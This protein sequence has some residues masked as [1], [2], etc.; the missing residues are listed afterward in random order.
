VKKLA[1]VSMGLAVG[2][3]LTKEDIIFILSVIVMIINAVIEYLK[4]RREMETSK[5]DEE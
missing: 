3:A 1:A 2:A 4:A 5:S